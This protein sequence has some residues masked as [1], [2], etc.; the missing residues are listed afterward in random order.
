M[1]VIGGGATGLGT[2]LDAASRGYKTLLLEKDDFAKGTTSKSTKLV[3]GGVRYLSQGELSLVFGA[4]RERGILLRNAPHT[5]SNL[6]FVIPAYR[7]WE[8]PWYGTGLKIYDR[9]AGNRSFGRSRLLSVA[10]AV[11]HLPTLKLGDLKGGILYHDGQFDDA[12]LAVNLMQT[13]FEQ[14]GVAVNYMEVT[15]FLK[16]GSKITG[17]RAVDRE[18][19]D[20][21]ELHARAVVN[22][23]G[24]FTDRIRSLA[25]PDSRP[26][27]RMSQG[28]HIVLDRRFQP[29]RSAMMIPRTSDKRVLFAVPWHD[30]VVIGTT[31]TPVEGPSN[32]PRPKREELEFLLNHTALYLKDAPEPDDVRS[33]FTGLRPLVQESGSS[34]TREISRDHAIFTDS[35]GLITITGGK[36]TT[37]RKMGEDTIEEVIRTAGL[38]RR[39]CITENLKLHGWTEPAAGRT[40]GSDHPYRLYGSDADELHDLEQTL[41]ASDIGSDSDG[42]DRDVAVPEGEPEIEGGSE[43]PLLH[44]ELPL[45]SAHVVWAVRNEMARTVE[46]VLSRRTRS[47]LLN[48]RASVEA[49]PLVAKIMAQELNRSDKWIEEQL[50]SY[51]ELASGYEYSSLVQK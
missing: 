11:D 39:P 28:T 26:L 38:E 4:L 19:G 1:L 25:N 46:D 17:V 12:R 2:A 43:S 10:E 23:T 49:A 14:G 24:V 41:S 35:S 47:L 31:D 7:W 8:K 6:S 42:E 9:M 36:W 3:H 40:E 29:G 16:S 45:R 20:A 50:K 15:G 33:A 37:Y 27:L 48:T 32:E 34:D 21:T 22:A 13:I 51:R 18:S 5:V 44:K 30:K